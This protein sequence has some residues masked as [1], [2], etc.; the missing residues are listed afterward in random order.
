VTERTIVI[1]TTITEAEGK[2]DK[3]I[4]A[5]KKQLMELYDSVITHQQQK[6]KEE[7]G[8]SSEPGSEL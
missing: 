1:R 7:G 8:D 5:K 4:K 2:G 6:K 3:R